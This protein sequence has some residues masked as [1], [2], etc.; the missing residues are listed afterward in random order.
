MR[1]AS[2]YIFFLFWLLASG[3]NKEYRKLSK[4]KSINQ[5]A[6]SVLDSI[7]LEN[8]ILYNTIDHLSFIKNNRPMPINTDSV[9]EIVGE[10]FNKLKIPVVNNNYIGDNHIDS[11]F[12]K[13]QVIKIKDIDK[14]W[15]KNIAGDTKDIMI[16]IPFIYIFNRITFTGYI[17]SGGIAG[18]NGFHLMTFLNM[19]VF[20]VKNNEIVYSSQALHTT[21]RTWADSRAEAEAIPPAPLVKQEHWDELV[22][23]TMEDYMKRLK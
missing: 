19:M 21:E 1:K 20:I 5:S 2:T 10:S 8:Y 12:Y 13:N 9:M 15:I 18:N 17:T 6:N 11:V 16:L 3:C 4:S 23:L 7:H 22:R 14:D